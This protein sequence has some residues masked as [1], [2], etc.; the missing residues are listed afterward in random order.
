MIAPSAPETAVDN[1]PGGASTIRRA[2]IQP[3]WLRITHWVNAIA[4]LIMVTSGWQIYDASPIF[5]SIYFPTAITLGGW[6]G[7][8]LLWHFAAMWLLAGNFL[9]YVTLNVVSGRFARM[10]LPLSLRGVAVD[11]WAALRGVLSHKD[12]S[13]YNQVQKLAYVAVIADIVLLIVSGLTLWKSVQ[14]PLLRNLLGGYD[15][16]RVVHFFAMALLVGFVAL[17]VVMAV[18]VPRSLLI[19]LRGR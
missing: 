7:G 19:I 15:A 5:P 13:R 1:S 2:R 12:L 8:A 17:H 11:L 4:V 3:R 14:F 6:L 9:I 16:A 10:L 18:L